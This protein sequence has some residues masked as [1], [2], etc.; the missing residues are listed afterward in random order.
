MKLIKITFRTPQK[1]THDG[2]EA[3]GIFIYC[4][5]IK[6]LTAGV[7]GVFSGNDVN[8]FIISEVKKIEIV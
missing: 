3:D 6:F 2:F 8:S 5:K 4:E 1:M 7:I